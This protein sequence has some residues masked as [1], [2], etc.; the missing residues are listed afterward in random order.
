MH[1]LW[2]TD[3]WLQ[4]YCVLNT[5]DVNAD[6]DPSTDDVSKEAIDPKSKAGGGGGGGDPEVSHFECER[7]HSM[8][9]SSLW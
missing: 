7:F 4:N 3:R 8:P 2:E 9:R 5:S 6:I 1:L